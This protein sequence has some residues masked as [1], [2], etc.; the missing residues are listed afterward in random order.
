MLNK[1]TNKKGIIV[2]MTAA[3][4]AVGMLAGCGGGTTTTTES[5]MSNDELEKLAK[6]DY[7][8]DTDRTIKIWTERGG[9]PAGNYSDPNEFPSLTTYIEELGVT[10][11]WT[12]ASPGQGAQQFNLLIASGELPDIIGY[13]YA[14]NGKDNIPGGVGKALRD[15]WMAPMNDYIDTY[16]PDYKK[17]LDENPEAA[18][19]LKTDDGIIYMAPY[20]ARA[21]ENETDGIQAGYM[22]RR[23]WLDELNLAI[24]ETIDEWENVLT[25]FKNEKGAVSPFSLRAINLDRGF[26]SAFDVHLGWYH[27]GD[28]VKYGYAEEKYKD[29][30][31]KMNDWYNKGLIDKDIA[32][33]DDNQVAS[34]MLNGQAGAAMAWLGDISKWLPAGQQLTPGYNLTF[35]PFPVANKGDLPK[36]GTKD[37]NVYFGG[38]CISG[39]SDKKE[40]AM[41]V[42]NYGFTEKG[43]E[44]LFY[45]KEGDTFEIVDGK[46]QFTDKIVK[47]PE[48]LT[49]NEAMAYY[50][51]NGNV[52]TNGENDGLRAEKERIFDYPQ[53]KEA[54][55]MLKTTQINN[56]RLPYVTPTE[57]EASEYS[58]LQ[59]DIQK[60]AEEMLAKF[61]VGEE[62]LSNFDNYMA[63]LK[64][65]GIDRL[66]EIMQSAYDRYQNR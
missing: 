1:I 22:L 25:R 27:E 45:G 48:G 38:W 66:T 8:I 54:V 41:K 62:P 53:Q 29:F 4:L 32:T 11:E 49:R 63:E 34:K 19:N 39:T 57:A 35:A 13:Y 14:N 55:E 52:P 30:L 17:F 7:P 21:D 56:Y 15:G 51:S 43:R 64:S 47:N 50:I 12:F 9:N 24:P 28:T 6:S 59:S 23:D 33:I 10:L 36:F 18:K 46:Y 26:S 31:T 44:Y 37:P 20:Y 2:K 16:A 58:R 65:R 40:L 60:Y 5:S 42:I 3:L 61:I